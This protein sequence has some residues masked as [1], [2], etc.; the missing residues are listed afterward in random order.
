MNVLLTNYSKTAL[1]RI[2]KSLENFILVRYFV[3]T[4]MCLPS[5]IRI[6]NTLKQCDHKMYKMQLQEFKLLYQY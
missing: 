1:T 3:L 5:S 2:I 6:S 4:E